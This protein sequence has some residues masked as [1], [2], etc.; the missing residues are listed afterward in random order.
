MGPPRDRRIS[1]ERVE[2]MFREVGL[3]VD[4][5]LNWTDNHFAALGTK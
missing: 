2:Q 3:T 1:R 4:A 5:Y